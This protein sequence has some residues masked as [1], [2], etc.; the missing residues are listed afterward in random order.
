MGDAIAPYAKKAVDHDIQD[1]WLKADNEKYVRHG[2]ELVVRDDPQ[3]RVEIRGTSRHKAGAPF[4]YADSLF[5]ALA[6]IKSITSLLYRHLQGMLAMTP[7]DEG[8]PDYATIY[9][10]LQSWVSRRTA[11][12][13]Q[14]PAGKCCPLRLQSTL[15]A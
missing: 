10:R 2:Q 14:S 11:T 1:N 13:S 5:V 6:I 15:P 4:R 8:S 3:R 9:K 7:R 12:H